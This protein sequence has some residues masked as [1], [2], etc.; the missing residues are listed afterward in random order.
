M[1]QH[2]SIVRIKAVANVL[3]SLKDKI[4]FVGGATV[5]LYVPKEITM[6]VRP[7]DDVD[8]VVEVLSLQAYYTLENA[9]R[10]VGFQQDMYSK[11]ICRYQIQG[12]TVDIMPTT[13]ILG[14]SNLWY[15]EAFKNAIDVL[16]DNDMYVKIF[17]VAYFIASK[18]E[19]FKSRGANDYRT[20]SDFEDIVY[21]LENRKEIIDDLAA[22]IGE[23]RNYLKIEFTNFLSNPNIE[24]GIYAHIQPHFAAKKTSSIM[25]LL[26]KF[27]EQ[28]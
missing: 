3:S 19:A 12:I 27:I 5:A 9:L 25:K 10:A 18:I 8:I 1:N 2:L 15:P 22:T 16:V 28:E 20:S 21:I 13:D 24:E 7:T 23:L 17:P 4:V 11:V 14:F 6:E 26:Q